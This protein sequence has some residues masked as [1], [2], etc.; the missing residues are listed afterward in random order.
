MTRSGSLLLLAFWLSSCDGGSSGLDDR[1]QTILHLQGVKYLSKDLRLI[2]T[3]A[4]LKLWVEH[5]KDGK[6]VSETSSQPSG[7][8]PFS[9]PPST[10]IVA[11]AW[12][13]PKDSGDLEVILRF[14][15]ISEDFGAK[16]DIELPPERG[17][18]W[19]FSFFGGDFL[20]KGEEELDLL[21]LYRSNVVHPDFKKWRFTGEAT[22]CLEVFVIKLAFRSPAS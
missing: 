21:A 9:C 14:P 2:E 22:P 13:N 20:L 3:P 17:V 19:A 6:L 10:R 7:G 18:S 5:W 8:G 1:T 4:H 12:E 11:A 16:L 15:E